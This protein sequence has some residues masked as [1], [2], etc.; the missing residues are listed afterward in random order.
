MGTLLTTAKMPAALAERIEAS[1][2]GRDRNQG[3]TGRAVLSPRLISVLRI[4]LLLG[5]ASAVA[6]IVVAHRRDVQRFER[7]RAALLDA[8]RVEGASLTA[9]DL[10]SLARAEAWL[11]VLGGPYEGDLV[12]ADIRSAQTE[13]GPAALD[14]ALSGPAVYVRGPLDAM[15]SK[16]G[17]AEAVGASHKDAFLLCLLDPPASHGEKALLVRVHAAYSGGAFLE[18]HTANVFRLHDEDTGLR[19]LLSPWIERV[20]AASDP[21]DLQRLQKEFSQAPVARGKE[22]AR[23]GLLVAVMDEAAVG[24]GPTDLDGEHAHPVRVGMVDLAN[25]RVVLRLRKVVDPKPW[26]APSRAQYAS[27]LDGCSL[28]LDVR[29]AVAR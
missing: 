12:A 1:V 20:R 5:A 14:A 25:A 28:A 10:G 24:G 7:E 18:Q 19:V 22:A 2:R 21:G 27:G 16:M 9:E 11:Q 8:V 17:V 15:A 4:A 29:E 13:R 26:S 6:S 23:A 3:L